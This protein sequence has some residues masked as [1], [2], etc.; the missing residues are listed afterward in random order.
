MPLPLGDGFVVDTGCDF[1]LILQSDLRDRLRA[2]GVR[3]TRQPIR[4]GRPVAAE[5]YR[6][7]ASVGGR[8]SVAEAY[9]PLS[10]ESDENLIGLPLLRFEA[11]CVRVPSRETWVGRAE[12]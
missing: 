1:D 8:W 9:F 10:P 5:R 3:S 6:V 4:W 11:L 12:K 2:A 7:Q